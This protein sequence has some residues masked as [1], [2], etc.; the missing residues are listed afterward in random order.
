MELG[1]PGVTPWGGPGDIGCDRSPLSPRPAG[2]AGAGAGA[3]GGG[4][5]DTALSGWG[6]NSVTSV[7]LYRD[8]KKLEKLQDGTELS[9]S[10]LQL[11]HSGRYRCR[12]RFYYGGGGGS[13]RRR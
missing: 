10:P 4:H 9:L 3:A 11:N 13:S 12:G 8:G 7:S 5:G 1:T 2:A 6:N